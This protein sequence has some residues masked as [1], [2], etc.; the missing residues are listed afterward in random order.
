M[1]GINDNYDQERSHMVPALIRR[2]YEAKQN[3]IPAIKLWGTG[4]VFREILCSDELADACLFF[5]NNYSGNDL[6]NIGSGIDYTIADI[7]KTIK[8]ISEYSG[9]IEFDSTKPDGMFKKQLDITRASGFGWNATN[10]LVADLKK[11]YEDFALNVQKYC[12]AKI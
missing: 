8:E 4:K 7:A 12:S 2:F 1:F 3:K 11:T 6:I 5:M 9:S 10:D